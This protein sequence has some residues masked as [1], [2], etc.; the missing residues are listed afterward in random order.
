[1]FYILHISVKKI[2]MIVLLVREI[3]DVLLEI[4]MALGP[5]SHENFFDRKRCGQKS[6]SFR[7]QVGFNHSC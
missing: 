1:M 3:C 4:W 2:I 5:M 7:F 6:Y